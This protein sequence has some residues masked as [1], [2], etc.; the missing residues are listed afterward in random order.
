MILSEK[1]LR[2]GMHEVTSEWHEGRLFKHPVSGNLVRF[3]SLPKEER[4]RL[5]RLVKEKYFRKRKKEE[6]TLFDHRGNPVAYIAPD[7]G[8][9]IYLWSGEPVAYLEGENIFRF[10]GKYL[11]WYERGIVCV[12]LKTYLKMPTCLLFYQINENKFG[13]NSIVIYNNL[14]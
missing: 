3:F 14:P 12:T 4:Q 8:N 11:G 9:T 7:E 1:D 5:D 2:V 10:N 13:V 6:I